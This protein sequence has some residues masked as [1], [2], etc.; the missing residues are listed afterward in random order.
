[1][2]TVKEVLT[3]E[4]AADYLQVD[5]ETIYR[6]IR[7]GELIASRIGR[8]YRIPRRSLDLFLWSKRTR[9]DISLRK[10]TGTDI[11]KFIE[12]D[13]MDEEEA[14][15]ASQFEAMIDDD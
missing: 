2:E 5:T 7:R 1:M 11:E 6:Y 15:I 14:R 9:D 12:Q 10:Y 8:T 3:A 4:Q 13:K